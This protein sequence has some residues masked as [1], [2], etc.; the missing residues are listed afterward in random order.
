MKGEGHVRRSGT[1]VIRSRLTLSF[2]E[3]LGLEMQVAEKPPATI[4]ALIVPQDV[5]LIMGEVRSIEDTRE[6][7]EEVLAAAQGEKA[8]EPGTVLLGADREG[9]A[10]VLQAVVYD[11]R[12]VPPVRAEHVFA[13]LVTAFEEARRRRIERLALW[14]LGTA[15]AG[16]ESRV[17]LR[18]LAQVCY[19]SAELGSSIRQVQLLL[20]S[21]AELLYYEDLLREQVHPR[22]DRDAPQAGLTS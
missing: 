12:T 20:G 2:G 14:P 5:N 17:F 1:G 10:L 6:T 3:K 15:H 4:E 22:R 7:A 13:A 18:L 19:S 21:S 11:F 16:L 9:E 8:H